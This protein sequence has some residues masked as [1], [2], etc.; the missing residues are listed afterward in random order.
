MERWV[1][2]GNQKMLEFTEADFERPLTRY[3]ELAAKVEELFDGKNPVR[4]IDVSKAMGR[5]YGTV[6]TQLHIA[7]K[8][9]LLT[10][11][12]RK[13]WLPIRRK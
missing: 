10:A 7:C 9:G 6:K 11:V 4:N 3:E 8:R 5:D 12:P 2:K 13:G 1:R